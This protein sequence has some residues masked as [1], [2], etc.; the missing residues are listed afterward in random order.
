M[1]SDSAGTATAI[2]CGQKANFYTVGVTDDVILENCSLVNQSKLK[3]I[4]KYG[5]DAG[6]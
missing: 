2:L 1:V 6:E 5:V 4:L 3:S